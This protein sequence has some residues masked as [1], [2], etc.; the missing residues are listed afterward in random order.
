VRVWD[1]A[2]VGIDGGASGNEVMG[3]CNQ[4]CTAL[5]GE[6]G[7]RPSGKRNKRRQKKKTRMRTVRQERKKGD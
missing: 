3:G 1:V 2:G 4:V 7:R 5:K 6:Y